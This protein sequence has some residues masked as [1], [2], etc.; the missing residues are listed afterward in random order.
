MPIQSATYSITRRAFAGGL[1]ALFLARPA[2]AATPIDEQGFVSIG[3]IDQWIAI[4]G[5]DINNP[6]IVYL[7][8]GPGE[9]QSPF[10][11][12]FEPWLKDFTVVN[13]DQRGAGK[14][15][16]KNG[17][18]MPDFNL[19]R[20]VEDA[21]LVSE[22][23][24]KKLGKQKLILVGQ[25]AGSMLGLLVA[26]RRPD[27]FYTCVGT[28]QMVSVKASVEWQEEMTHA[29]PTHDAAEAKALHAWG[30]ESPPDQPY[31]KRMVEFT[32]SPGHPNP[33]GATWQ[34]GYNFEASKVGKEMAAFD[35]MTDA[36]DLPVPYILIQ[37]REDRL[38]PAV[39]A[40]KYF[41]KVRSN[42]KV[43]VAIDG[44]HFACFTHAGQFVAALR[45]AVTPLIHAT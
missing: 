2:F 32:G 3:G 6:V 40:K 16:E 20:L 19:D 23:A 41:E 25:S 5:A 12:D 39:L 8:G 10:L 34:A 14:T 11:K 33:A 44:G 45:K 30:L 26:K 24:L 15:Y 18:S 36:A 4:Q 27:L 21:V 1:S 37:G 28:A 29:K 35:A 7:H 17:T 38:T 22:Y 31:I 9:A 42:G 13:W 43:Y